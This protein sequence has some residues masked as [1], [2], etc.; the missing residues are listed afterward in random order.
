MTTSTT[1]TI[2]YHGGTKT[3]NLI[4]DLIG[5]L[6]AVYYDPDGIFIILSFSNVK[7]HHQATYYSKGTNTFTIYKEQG[8]IRRIHETLLGLDLAKLDRS[9]GYISQ[10]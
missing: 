8:D 1:M 5:Y 2:K 6:D 9:L 10:Y 3:T 7:R 4:G